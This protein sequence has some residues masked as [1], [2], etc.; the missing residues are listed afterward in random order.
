MKFVVLAGLIAL[1][2]TAASAQSR[3]TRGDLALEALRAEQSRQA[4]EAQVQAGAVAQQRLETDAALQRLEIER[5]GG[6]TLNPQGPVSGGSRTQ[7]TREQA[8]ELS[9]PPPINPSAT[10]PSDARTRGNLPL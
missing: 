10:P 8:P 4:L 2:G 5:R 9:A 1:C 6:A 3:V 7:P